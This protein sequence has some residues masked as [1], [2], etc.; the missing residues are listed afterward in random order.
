MALKEQESSEPPG[1]SG[2][3]LEAWS[4]SFTVKPPARGRRAGVG[5]EAVW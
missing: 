2:L 5:T 1:G 4:I 3:I